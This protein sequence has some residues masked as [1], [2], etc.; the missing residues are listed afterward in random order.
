MMQTIPAR[1]GFARWL[2]SKDISYRKA[3]DLW[4]VSE[5]A[6]RMIMKG[7]LSISDRMLIR[8]TERMKEVEK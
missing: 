2:T 8:I 3:A 1:K 4:G 6:F 7:E 5:S